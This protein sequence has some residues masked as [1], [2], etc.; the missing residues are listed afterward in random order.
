MCKTKVPTLKP[1]IPLKTSKTL[2]TSILGPTPPKILLVPVAKQ[3][4]EF[5]TYMITKYIISVISI[6]LSYLSILSG[7]GDY[8]GIYDTGF[9]RGAL[10]GYRPFIECPLQDR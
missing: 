9:K 7:G 1:S 4:Q 2:I 10:M 3:T 5:S 6:N 8:R